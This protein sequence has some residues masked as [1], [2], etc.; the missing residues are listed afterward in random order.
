MI[1]CFWWLQH[2]P[3]H[4]APAAPVYRGPRLHHRRHHRWRLGLWQWTCVVTPLVGVPGIAWSWGGLPSGRVGLPSGIG[5]GAP[6]DTIASV[7]EPS[8]ALMLFTALT[9]AWALANRKRHN[10]DGLLKDTRQNAVKN[11]QMQDLS[12]NELK[13]IA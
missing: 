12:C 4:R 1:K 10:R 2:V 6:S 7:P 11:S 3:V 13:Q 8:S 9:I 5:V